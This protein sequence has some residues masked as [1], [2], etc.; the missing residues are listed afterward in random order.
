M[1][2]FPGIL[3]S[4]DFSNHMMFDRKDLSLALKVHVLFFF[5]LDTGT[6]ACLKLF[7]MVRRLGLIFQNTFNLE[8]FFPTGLPSP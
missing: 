5:N 7:F 1:Q 2:C 6:F 8:L 3:D 4:M